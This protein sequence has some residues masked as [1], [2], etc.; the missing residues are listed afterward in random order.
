MT[1]VSSLDD[2][3]KLSRSKA[4]RNELAQ[5]EAR[6]TLATL[7]ADVDPNWRYRTERVVRNLTA[8]QTELHIAVTEDPDVL[9]RTLTAARTVAQGWENLARLGDH[10]ATPTALLNAALGYEL[11]GY[12]ANAAC[13]ARLV[14]RNSA[15]TTDPSIDGVLA[16][17][18]QRLF[19]RVR[20]LREPLTRLPADP[21]SLSLD[22]LTRRASQAVLAGAL[23]D[24]ATYFLTGDETVLEGATSQLSIAARG[25]GEV[26]DAVLYNAA[27]GVG[28]LLPVMAERSIWRQLCNIS[29]SP[30]WRRYLNVLARGLGQNVLDSRSISELW[31]SQR[32]A[33]D[34]GLLSSPTSFA[35]RMPTSAGKT[36]V[37][38][39]AMVHTL[40]ENM[41]SKCLYIAPFRALVTEIEDAFAN[42]FQDLGYSASTVPGAYDQ[43]EFGALIASTDDVLVLTPEK[44]DLLFRLQPDLLDAVALVVIDEGH[45]VG[46]INRGPKFEL[47]I[48]RLRRRI[49]NAR[50]LVLSAVVP[51]RTLKDFS[52]W[53]GGGAS[54]PITTA[55]RPSLLRHGKLEWRGLQGTLRFVGD[56]VD[57]DALPFVPGIIRQRTYEHK[58]PETGRIRRPRFP[59]TA[60]KGEITAEL[61]YAYAVQGPVLVFAMQTNWT[62]SVAE[63]L[64]RR[65][66]LTELIGEDSHSAFRRRDPTRAEIVANEWLG[67]DHKVTALLRRGIAFHNS[68][69][70]EAV[71]QAIERDFR[72]R[73][74]AVLVATTTLA[75]GVNLPVRTVIM[76]STRAGEADG[77]QRR[78]LARDYWNIAGRAG[79]AGEE[80]IGTCVHIV[81]TATDNDDFERYVDRRDR[82]EPV[83]SALHRLLRDLVAERISTTDAARQLDSDLLALLVEEDQAV[84]DTQL[85]AD[86]LESSLFSIQAIEEKISITPLIELMTNT[87]RTI[88]SNIPNAERRRLYASTGLSSV[89]CRILSDHA[90]S[91]ASDV[92]QLLTDQS[93]PLTELTDLQVEALSG[94]SEM[95]SDSSWT[96]DDR[97]LMALWLE[98]NPVAEIASALNGESQ[99]ITRYIEEAFSYLLPW[100]ISAFLRIAQYELK[101]PQLSPLAVNSAGM[102][103]YGVPTVEAVWAMTAGLASRRA[104]TTVATYYAR[105]R[106]ST[107]PAD[108]RRWL[109]QRNP[110]SLHED[111]GLTGIELESTARA[112]LRSQTNKYLTELEVTGDVLPLET[113][114]APSGHAIERGLLYD[115][116]IGDE[117]RLVRDRD[118]QL[119]RNAIY[120]MIGN[121]R[122]GYLSAD[123]AQALGPELDSGRGVRARVTRIVGSPGPTAVRISINGV[124]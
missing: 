5:I 45:I 57:S 20:D 14:A 112:V 28:H 24:A 75:Q 78:L 67:A 51:D 114:C 34:G 70:P 13:L 18:L 97:S 48:S 54:K 29:S 25:F 2:T 108:F 73:N 81:R 65:I 111:L 69:L 101:L 95:E 3:I 58:H 31:P 17:F 122:F 36:R 92:S 123:A 107:S 21:A 12:Q 49:P 66:D 87:A 109:S 6:A 100:G 46:D 38:E 84:L 103:K 79:R 83:E 77:S 64:G 74:L 116:E 90:L 23:S 86:T 10:V 30:R 110:D 72:N 94:L 61:A 40:V 1:E 32:A 50:F 11:A 44:L 91:H 120:V 124:P 63:A 71:R 47:L 52:T 82:V 99:E 76:H 68:R 80:T 106:Q 26:G 55:W 39:L 15:W 102:V 7:E 35:I 118:S 42:L 43:D 22:D 37:A 115:L 4:L 19:L 9:S 27:T 88:V 105:Q 53:I 60:N 121:Q 93:T 62:Q 8:I 96:G 119:N 33:L 85:L 98:G 59:E 56:R 16:A 117:V 89:S 104:A 41:G 113:D